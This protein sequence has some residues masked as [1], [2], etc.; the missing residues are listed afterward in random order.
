MMFVAG[1][2]VEDDLM[3]DDDSWRAE[4]EEMGMEVS[5]PMIEHRGE[6]YFKGLAF[7]DEITKHF[8]NRLDRAL[9]LMEHY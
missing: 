7:Y 1:I 3:G 8:C 6:H 9:Q 5:C 4:L 2:H